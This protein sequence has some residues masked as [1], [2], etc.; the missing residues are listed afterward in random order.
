MHKLAK[1]AM[2]LQQNISRTEKEMAA[3]EFEAS[4]GGDM[5]KVKINGQHRLVAVKIS[6][7]LFAGQDREMLEDLLIAAF[8]QAQELAE[9]AKNDIIKKTAGSIDP[10]VIGKFT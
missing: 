2:D 10:S 8:N 5:V 9:K 4:A 7:E 1:L 6:D 3:M